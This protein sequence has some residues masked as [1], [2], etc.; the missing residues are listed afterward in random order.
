MFFSNNL[1]YFCL[2]KAIL[3][4]KL[5]QNQEIKQEETIK[6]KLTGNKESKEIKF[7]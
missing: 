4:S 1:I 3:T 2:F 5:C 6:K 7:I